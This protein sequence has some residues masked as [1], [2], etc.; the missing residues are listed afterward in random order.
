MLPH[1]CRKHR[2]EVVRVLHP[3]VFESSFR[4][5]PPPRA[6]CVPQSDPAVVASAWSRFGTASV[7]LPKEDQLT[8]PT[9]FAGPTLRYRFRLRGH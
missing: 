3:H 1:R 5:A 7:L 6:T 4:A 9:V 2:P 8:R